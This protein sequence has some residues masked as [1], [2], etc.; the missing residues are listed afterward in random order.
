MAWSPQLDYLARK[1]VAREARA[2]SNFWNV[3][4]K[5]LTDNVSAKC[6][7]GEKDQAEAPHKAQGR[8]CCRETA[9]I[10]SCPVALRL[11]RPRSAAHLRSVR[12]LRA[13]QRSS[14]CWCH[15]TDHARDTHD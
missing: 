1:A 12:S 13:S 3:A 11:G 6:F 7:Q 10:R 5:G 9:R 4:G 15:E 14:S 2:R 8:P